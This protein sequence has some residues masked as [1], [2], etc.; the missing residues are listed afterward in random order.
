M[1]IVTGA[2]KGLGLAIARFLSQNGK[3]VVG[4]SR[5]KPSEEVDFRF[6]EG[7]ISSYSSLQEI[8]QTLRGEGAKVESL[9]CAA[10]VA[11]MNLAL[12]TPEKV[13][14]KVIE[15]NLMGTIFSNQL[16]SKLM[17]RSGGTIINFSTIAVPLALSGESI[18]VASKAGVE[19][20]SRT[21]AREVS[22]HGIRVNCIAPGPIRTDLLKGVSDTQIKSITD[23]QIIQRSFEKQDVV[24]LVSCLLD[25]RLSSISGEVFHI[26][27]V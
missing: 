10:G 4:I 8:A 20:F 12:M 1:I 6:I 5:T 11:S 22:A 23:R 2:S 9:I 14:R 17:L 13:I 15:I 7:D 21:F 26:G 25:D 18:Y 19:G 27:G 24:D 16:F 3:E